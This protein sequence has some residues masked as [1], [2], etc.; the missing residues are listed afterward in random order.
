MDILWV[1][2]AAPERI[3][4]GR[5]V[6]ANPPL[7]PAGKQQADRL[8]DWLGHERIDAVLSSPQARAQETAAPIA[9]AQGLAVKTLDGLVEYDVQSDHYIPIEELRATND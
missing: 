6:P 7:T 9:A 4:S 5:G 3:E 8:A 1:R 2:H